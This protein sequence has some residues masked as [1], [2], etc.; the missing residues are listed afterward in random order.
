[1]ADII[2]SNF[3]IF[4]D[5]DIFEDTHFMKG[6]KKLSATPPNPQ[7][8]GNK[9]CSTNLLLLEAVYKILGEA[10][11]YNSILLPQS[12]RDISLL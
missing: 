8:N 3:G 10:R 12:V 11:P 1:M 2:F 5:T 4:F 9:Y 7:S 6:Q